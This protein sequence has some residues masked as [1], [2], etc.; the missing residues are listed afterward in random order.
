MT[1]ASFI[2]GYLLTLVTCIVA[3]ADAAARAYY[4]ATSDDS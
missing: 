2:F 1:V 4:E 3:T